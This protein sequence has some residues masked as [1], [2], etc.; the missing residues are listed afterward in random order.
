MTI[1]KDI[2]R[3]FFGKD[4]GPV[5][6]QFAKENGGEYAPVIDDRVLIPYKNFIITFD[7]FTNYTISGGS[8][9]K[10]EYT[11]GLVE[12]NASDNFKLLITQQGFLENVGKLFGSQDIQIGDAQFD[13]RFMVKSND[14]TK[15]LLMLSNNS[16]T[17]SLED[18]KSIRLDITNG[19]GL[20][21]EKPEEGNYMLYY[22]LDGKI[23]HIN[24]LNILYQLF[25]NTID[26]LIK[27]CSIK[28]T[29][30]SS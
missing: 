24:Q 10:T 13:K 28:Q 29:K 16:I 18:L 3:Y 23:T 12:F 21:N 11:R 25:T 14:E 9:Y 27:I 2:Y 26:T 19:E 1:I 4:F 6:Q 22:V 20:W 17:K 8:A 7:A 30:A 15:T 5:W